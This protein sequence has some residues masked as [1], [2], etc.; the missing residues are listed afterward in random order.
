M[1]TTIPIPMHMHR[2]KLSSAVEEILK[3]LMKVIYSVNSTRIPNNDS[4][5]PQLPQYKSRHGEV[6]LLKCMP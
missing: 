4:V 2:Q 5:E 1:S 3:I 6:N